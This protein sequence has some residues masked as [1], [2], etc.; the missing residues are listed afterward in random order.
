MT[1][2]NPHISITKNFPIR[3]EHF[4]LGNASEA[5]INLIKQ[6][7]RL[8]TAICQNPILSAIQEKVEKKDMELL[9]KYRKQ[10]FNLDEIALLCREISLSRAID[11]FVLVNEGKLDT[12]S[13]QAIGFKDIIK[14]LYDTPK[15]VKEIIRFDANGDI[16]PTNSRDLSPLFAINNYYFNEKDEIYKSFHLNRKRQNKRIKNYLGD[17]LLDEK[18][19][20]IELSGKLEDA[21]LRS[22]DIQEDDIKISRKEFKSFIRNISKE[23]HLYE[24]EDY[25]LSTSPVWVEHYSKFKNFRK[26]EPKIKEELARRRIL[27]E[28]VSKLNFDDFKHVMQSTTKEKQ[29]DRKNIFEGAIHKRVKDIMKDKRNCETIEKYL[30]LN[31]MPNEKIQ[32]TMELM[33]NKGILCNLFS[34]HHIDHVSNAFEHQDISKLNDPKNLILVSTR[35]HSLIHS[36]DTKMVGGKISLSSPPKG[37]FDM[38]L[39]VTPMFQT[40][41][42]ISPEE[43]YKTIVYIQNPYTR[44]ERI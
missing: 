14:D 1:E 2:S 11:A 18:G 41:Y 33:K 42:T 38:M 12:F 39:G 10:G 8:E 5:D 17:Y 20:K 24:A 3:A 9:L 31:N 22:G 30:R 43:K 27:P 26:L 44:R 19:K 4:K 25:D 7:N 37:K 23:H 40:P 16:K 36:G 6:H 13:A 15:K 29:G 35:M 21:L 32:E 34:I 28:I